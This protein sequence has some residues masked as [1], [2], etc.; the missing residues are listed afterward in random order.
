MRPIFFSFTVL[1]NKL[2]RVKVEKD[3][4][5]DLD[6]QSIS[7]DELSKTV[8]VGDI[9]LVK[10]LRSDA[11]RPYNGMYGRVTSWDDSAG[12]FGIRLVD[13]KTLAVKPENL[14]IGLKA[15]E[16]AADKEEFFLN[17]RPSPESDM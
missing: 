8:E 5:D 17:L 3:L 14:E 9:A 12:R 10:G 6:D 16:G 11:G 1:G 15:A 13:K 2:L 7:S 4:Q